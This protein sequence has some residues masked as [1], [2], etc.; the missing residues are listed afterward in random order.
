MPDLNGFAHLDLTVNDLQGSLDWWRDV[1]GFQPVYA[2]TGDGFVGH[3]V[4]H[5]SGM[6]IGLMQFDGS[7]A[8]RFDER[9]VGLDHLSFAVSDREELDRWAVHLDAH[10]V[11]NSGVADTP[12]GSVLTFRDPDNS[13]LELFVQLDSLAAASLLKSQ[14]TQPARA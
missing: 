3:A 11:T 13:Q 8:D 1:M 6:F 7:E 14:K 12:V 2:F 5:P 10:G 9:R 4:G